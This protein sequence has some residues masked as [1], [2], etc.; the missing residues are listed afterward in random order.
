MPGRI[1]TH[2]RRVGFSLKMRKEEGVVNKR[3]PPLTMGKK[4]ALSIMPERRRFS[5][6]LSAVPMPPPRRMK[7]VMT[8]CHV[9]EKTILSAFSFFLC[10][11]S[12]RISDMAVA[13]VKETIKNAS[14]SSL[15]V[16]F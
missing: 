1:P 4:T 7:T 2:F 12:K 15:C 8:R 11:Q 16:E 14:D 3:G 9:E 5:L 10:K 6:L 13:T